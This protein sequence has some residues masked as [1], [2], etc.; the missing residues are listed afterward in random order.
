MSDI[1]ITEVGIT[2]LDPV[3][4]VMNSAFD[5]GYGEA[6][7][8]TQ[9]MS[10]LA[11][12]GAWLSLARIDGRPAGFALNRQIADEAELLLL[13]VLPDYRRRGVAMALIDR[14]RAILRDR[15]GIRLHL[16]VRHNNPAIELYKKAGFEQ[17]GRR[18]GYYR[19]LDGQI[20]DALTLS[21]TLTEA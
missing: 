11:M 9:A 1:V 17:I 6:W 21:C 7:N 8:E 20:H 19:S 10:M 5:P 18:P 16:E 4:E 3:M 15:N 2:G 13:A 14:S 12:P